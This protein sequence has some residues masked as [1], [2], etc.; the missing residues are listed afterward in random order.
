M[1]RSILIGLIAGQR[2]MTPLSIVAGE[3]AKGH[4]GADMP[5]A[6]LIA[7]PLGRAGAVT[8][9]AA[10]MAGDKMKT[11]P[12]RTVLAGLSA[13]ALTSG[14]AGAALARPGQRR[15]GAALAVTAAIASSYLGLALRKRAMQR[16]GQTATGFVEDA[17][18][19][20]GGLAV[21]NMRR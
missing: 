10:E 18:L 4:V 2:A 21:A 1:L 16:F 3:A 7:H 8:L 13:R 12:D 19:L 6:A 15:V 14:F 9:A 17:A 20:A 5:G 11:A